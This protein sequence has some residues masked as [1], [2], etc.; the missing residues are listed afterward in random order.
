MTA[1]AKYPRWWNHLH[2]EGLASLSRTDW[3]RLPVLIEEAAVRGTDRGTA[4]NV[5]DN[6]VSAGR[7]EVKREPVMR[8]NVACGEWTYF[9]L[10]PSSEN[11]K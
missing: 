6:L 7:A 3:R 9:R 5:F 10:A 4:I 8:G 1:P 2:D 11:G